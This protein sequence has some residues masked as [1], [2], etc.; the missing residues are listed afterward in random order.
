MPTE[1]T[2]HT[3]TKLTVK[4]YTESV[5][6]GLGTFSEAEKPVKR[7]FK[8]T[9]TVDTIVA[10]YSTNLIDVAAFLVAGISVLAVN[11]GS[12]D[13]TLDIFIQGSEDDVAANFLDVNANP[14]MAITDTNRKRRARFDC[15]GK[16]IRLR[17]VVTGTTIDWD[18]AVN[19]IKKD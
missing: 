19:V 9:F 12:G 7:A 17:C 15:Y 8:E 14:D 4:D 3:L 1:S 16:N 13:A 6:T 2:P 18:I 10:A 11:N 5:T